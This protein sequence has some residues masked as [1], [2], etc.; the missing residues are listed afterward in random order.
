MEG[1]RGLRGGAIGEEEEEKRK[2]KKK[3]RKNS[4]ESKHHRSTDITEETKDRGKIPRTLY[5]SPRDSGARENSELA[6]AT[7]NL[8]C[9]KDFTSKEKLFFC[10]RAN[11]AQRLLYPSQLQEIYY[12][13]WVKI[14]Q[15][16]ISLEFEALAMNHLRVISDFLQKCVFNN[17]AWSQN[18]FIMQLL[19]ECTS[20]TVYEHKI[21][22]ERQYRCAF[23]N[24]RKDTYQ[25][26]FVS[27]AD[28]EPGVWY[29][30]NE[31]ILPLI[32]SLH[33]LNNVTMY[34]ERAALIELQKEKEEEGGGEEEEERKE[35]EKEFRPDEC[36]IYK[37]VVECF[38]VAVFQLMAFSE[39]AENC[40]L[41]K[42]NSAA[43]YDGLKKFLAAM[44]RV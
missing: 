39:H 19:K 2:Q 12:Y 9:S 43:I 21:H 20:S 7:R 10:T 32:D 16:P 26:R 11:S 25:I 14:H 1:A 15:Q 40:H 35:K 41:Q 42:K 17:P 22:K 13:V 3:K 28:N 8:I 18:L 24:V 6:T 30:I 31:T 4:R 44:N 29:I 34:F 27:T 38:S 36:E 37:T 33:L 5:S 23:T